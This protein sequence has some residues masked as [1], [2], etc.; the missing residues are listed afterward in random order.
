[1]FSCCFGSKKIKTSAT[2]VDECPVCL[3]TTELFLLKNCK[4]AFCSDC[5]QQWFIT[6]NDSNVFNPTSL[7]QLVHCVENVSCGKKPIQKLFVHRSVLKK[8]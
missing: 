1:M 2:L 4:H 5:I 8:V 3:E 6:S 7:T